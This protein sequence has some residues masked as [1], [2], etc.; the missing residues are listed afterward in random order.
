MLGGALEKT[1]A[2]L[3]E[4]NTKITISLTFPLLFFFFS[5]FSLFSNSLTAFL[6]FFST[7]F[8]HF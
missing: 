7:F 1:V 6:N 3:E 4:E 2:D 5:K 8:E